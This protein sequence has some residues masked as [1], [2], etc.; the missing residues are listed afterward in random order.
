M[1]QIIIAIIDQMAGLGF[2][3]FVIA[4]VRIM[5]EKT[6][7]TEP[8]AKYMIIAISMAAVCRFVGCFRNKYV[9][10]RHINKAK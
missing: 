1:L 9:I 4:R 3:R 2:S 6:S 5:A 7:A 8:I 10:I